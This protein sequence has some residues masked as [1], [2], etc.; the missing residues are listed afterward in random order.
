MT[1]DTGPI[2][3]LASTD[4]STLQA[5]EADLSRRFGHD[6]RIV[7]ADDPARGL[8]LLA[9][10][11]HGGEPVALV[12]AE[13]RMTGTPGIEFL[14]RAHELHPLAKR[15]LLVER[16]FTATNPIVPAMTLGQIDYHLVKPWFP[17]QRLYLPISE[18][19]TS[20]AR[21]QSSGG[22]MFKVAAP[23]NSVRAHE[24]RDLL[25][26]FNM[27]FAFHPLDT[28]EGRAVLREVGHTGSTVPVVVRRDGRVLVD[29]TDADLVNAA[30][31]GTELGTD[32]Y[33]VAIVGAGPA[34][35]ASAVYAA[36]E[37]L[38]TLLL[39]RQISGG[40]AGSS[41]RLR[42]VPGFTWGIAG[43]DL[44]YRA[45]EQAWLFGANIVFAQKATRLRP[46]GDE[47]VLRVADGQEVSA[48]TV[49]LALGVVWRRLGIPRLEALI[50]AGVFYGAAASEAQ[51]MRG[52]RVCVLGG[53]NSAGQAAAH[54]A[55]YAQQVTLLVR[56]DSLADSMSEYLITELEATPNIRI[57][58]GTELLDGHGDDRLK[59]ILVRDRSTGRTELMDT[60]GL[61][62]MIGNEPRTEW[63]DGVV[64]RDEEGF[65]LTGGQLE[66][67]DMETGE[68]ARPTW[69][70]ERP[71][72][73]LETSLPGVFAVG[74]VRHGSVKRVTTAMGD[75]A[76]VVHLIH[77]YLQGARRPEPALGH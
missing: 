4:S 14:A 50:G 25:T 66:T 57:R 73:M 63:L 29:P 27:P 10:F 76:T 59:A 46:S 67:S 71:A 39:E 51:A 48:R 30:G 6:T 20:W 77:E 69:P 38:S 24:I 53:G 9:R 43:A 49:V 52:E 64:A 19:L 32:A 3:F 54:L 7:G 42:N 45:C 22:E 70:L 36:S 11:A 41:S 8:D 17:D 40:Q 74:D 26:R 61:F 15:I 13:H 60:G 65:I 12:I 33:D 28:P 21:S 56:S 1:G 62:V 47:L 72:M 68:G 34:G 35:L 55:R 5:L 23:H 37:G 2:I 18:F 75:G 44:A 31:G 16:D 58:L